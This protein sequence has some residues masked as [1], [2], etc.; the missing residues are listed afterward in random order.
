[1]KNTKGQ[2]IVEY[3]MLV[4]MI[5]VTI[6]VAIRNTNI[7]IYRLWTGLARQVAKPC[8]TCDAP[9]APDIK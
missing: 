8:A 6:A 4:V 5:A 3:L 9:A 1:M 2:A 7:N